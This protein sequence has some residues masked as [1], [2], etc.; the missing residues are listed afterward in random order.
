MRVNFPDDLTEPVSETAAYSFM[1]GVNDYYTDQSYDLTSLTA[2]VTP[3]MT[4]PQTKAYYSAAG[5]GALMYDARLAARKAGFEDSNYDRDIVCFTAVPDFDFGGLAAVGGKGVWLQSP[6]VGVT[7]HE[8]GHN[9][10]LFHANS[11]NTTNQSSIGPGTNNEYGNIYDTMGSGG[12]AQFNAAHK[13]ILGWLPDTVVHNI[14][15]NGVYRIYPYDTPLRANGNFYAGRIRKDFQR[16]YWFEF[17]QKFPANRWVSNGLLLNWAPWDESNGGTHLL[18]TT[19]GSI[20]PNQASFRNSLEDAALVV[21]RTF[22]DPAGGV[23][24]TPLRR[25]AASS[26]AWMDVQV[27]LGAF[28]GNQPPEL[29]LGSAAPS[30]AGALVHSRRLPGW[31]HARLRLTFDDFTF[32]Q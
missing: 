31:R 20:T 9:Y 7:S 3:L 6:G 29:R 5:P 25:D 13:S 26:N 12:V 10:G 32:D 4:L 18:D 27:N 16:Q 17:R 2:T 28:P 19:P 23:H 14:T 8:L 1:D 30:H 11:W 15:T 24:I 21:G 22:N